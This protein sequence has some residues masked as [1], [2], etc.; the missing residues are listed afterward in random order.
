MKQDILKAVKNIS[1]GSIESMNVI[2][3][4]LGLTNSQEILVE[5]FKIPQLRT[6]KLKEISGRLEVKEKD[7]GLLNSM[8]TIQRLVLRYDYVFCQLMEFQDF[9]DPESKS[10]KSGATSQ[11]AKDGVSDSQAIDKLEEEIQALVK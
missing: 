3:E 4:R 5:F 1:H 11:K 8:I 2:I 7:I 6:P 9:S 10:V